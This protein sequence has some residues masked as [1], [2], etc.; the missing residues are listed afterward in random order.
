MLTQMSWVPGD[1]SLVG[2]AQLSGERRPER[3]REAV[4]AVFR[5]YLSLA[6]AGACVV[7]AVN[8]AFVRAWV[9]G[10]LFAGP[11]VNGLLAGLIVVSTITHG[12]A[13]VTSVL[14]RRLHVGVATLISGAIQ[15]GAAVVLARRFG[16]IGIPIAALTAQLLVLIPSLVPAFAERAS[17]G[18]APFAREVLRPWLVR[19][20]PFVAI[21]VLAGPM[22]MPIPKRV[23]IPLGGC[24][25][26]AYIW[27]VR[28][29]VIGYPPVAA[30]IRSRL[31][32]VRLDG[33]LPLAGVE[34][35]PS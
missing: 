18:A 17:L 5:V 10:H 28:R 11:A 34:Q 30:I 8:G 13:T 35:P 12:T 2:L 4:A 26:V 3:L 19:S 31:A 23:S 14:G 21:C 16:V 29:L 33:L 32:M 7:L 24:I 9:G 1:S 27:I 22:L 6:T 25:A 20:I 15:V